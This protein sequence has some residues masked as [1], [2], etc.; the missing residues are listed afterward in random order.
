MFAALPS[1][2]FRNG[3]VDTWTRYYVCKQT[4]FFFIPKKYKTTFSPQNV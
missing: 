1:A 2:E 4:F 3:Q